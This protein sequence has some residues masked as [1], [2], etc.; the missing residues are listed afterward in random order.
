MRVLGELTPSFAEDFDDSVSDVSY[1]STVLQEEDDHPGTSLEEHPFDEQK[2]SNQRQRESNGDYGQQVLEYRVAL[3]EQRLQDIVPRAIQVP[4]DS[5][6]SSIEPTPLVKKKSDKKKKKKKSGKKAKS[7]NMT[8]EKMGMGN[9]KS[10]SVKDVVVSS[11]T[12]GSHSSDLTTTDSSNSDVS[13][14]KS[15]THRH[16]KERRSFNRGSSG[17]TVVERVVAPHVLTRR[18]SM[19]LLHARNAV[20]A[21]Q[22]K[23]ISSRTLASPMKQVHEVKPMSTLG[24]TFM[25]PR[26]VIKVSKLPGDFIGLT[27]WRSGEDIYVQ[28]IANSSAFE[29]TDLAPGQQL[30]AVNGISCT[31]GN[32]QK[33]LDF[34]NHHVGILGL[35]VSRE[36]T[37]PVFS[38]TKLKKPGQSCGIQLRRQ[39]KSDGYVEIAKISPHGP[40][41][42]A[43][44]KVGMQVLFIN[45][46]ACQGKSAREAGRYLSRALRSVSITVAKPRESTTHHP[47]IK[48]FSL[49]PQYMVCPLCGYEGA[50]KTRL[51][52]QDVSAARKVTSCFVRALS[53]FEMPTVSTN[54]Y[55][56]QCAEFLGTFRGMTV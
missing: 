44:L 56:P 37:S 28:G 13:T 7:T 41:A 9:A 46:N 26:M 27:L 39:R 24:G 34:L 4:T 36:V 19:P 33:I 23:T 47:G 18:V 8:N 25:Y 50:T 5:S 22:R 51:Q 3:A 15:S 55:C 43:G 20:Q 12:G 45:G 29:D 32:P 54:H 52:R 6:V 11:A 38:I 16:S 17:R 53:G 14:E 31:N 49:K 1:S 48:L 30:F 2:R 40:F 35:V 21:T 42:E 10:F